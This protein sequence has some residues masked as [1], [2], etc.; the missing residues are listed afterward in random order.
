MWMVSRYSIKR[1]DAADAC[2]APFC[3][4]LFSFPP[5]SSS[6]H[7]HVF[8]RRGGGGLCP[9]VWF[10]LFFVRDAWIYPRSNWPE[11]KTKKTTQRN[12]NQQDTLAACSGLSI[13]EVSHHG[14]HKWM[15]GRP[16]KTFKT[17]PEDDVD[18]DDDDEDESLASFFDTDTHFIICQE[19]ITK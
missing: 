12:I 13:L 8:G 5:S 14:L 2:S 11:K 6:S 4:F 10:G 19:D 7:H 15:D 17:C 16:E 18:V 9:Y 3:S 1:R